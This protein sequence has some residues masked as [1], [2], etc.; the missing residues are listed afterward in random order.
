MFSVIRRLI[1]VFFLDRVRRQSSVERGL[2]MNSQP[3]FLC[4]EGLAVYSQTPLDRADFQ[5]T[6][7]RGISRN[8][9][10]VGLWVDLLI[11]VQGDM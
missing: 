11:M 10:E 5:Y 1:Y 3:R 9:R 8:L 7:I 2:T 4:R 6:Y